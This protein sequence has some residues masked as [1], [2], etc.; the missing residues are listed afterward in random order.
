VGLV[1]VVKGCRN[2]AA[3]RRTM[4]AQDIAADSRVTAKKSGQ[5]SPR[6][7]GNAKNKPDATQIL[8]SIPFFFGYFVALLLS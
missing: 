2:W 7:P 8:L 5:D 6:R 4:I 3:A 1:F